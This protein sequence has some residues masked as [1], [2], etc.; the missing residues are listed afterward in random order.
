MLQT[1]KVNESP[2]IKTI[3]NIQFDEGKFLS[4]IF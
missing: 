3:K 2:I 4:T 1:L